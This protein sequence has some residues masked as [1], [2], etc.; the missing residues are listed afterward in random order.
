MLS[1]T[2]FTGNY[3]SQKPELRQFRLI[4]KNETD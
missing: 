1:H 4:T 3:V 2:S